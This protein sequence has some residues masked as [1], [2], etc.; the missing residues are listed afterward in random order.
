[1]NRVSF[2]VQ[3][4]FNHYRCLSS[5]QD[6]FLRILVNSELLFEEFLGEI[7][8][9]ICFKKFI[10]MTP[11]HSLIY[12]VNLLFLVTETIGV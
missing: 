8:Y 2:C 6:N 1:M 7:S 10:Q 9:N 12:L 3:R 4:I 5:C 11:K